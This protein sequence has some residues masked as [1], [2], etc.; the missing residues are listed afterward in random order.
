SRDQD[1]KYQYS[2]KNNEKMPEKTF[3]LLL[4]AIKY[5]KPDKGLRFTT[6][7]ALPKGSGLAGSS[8]LIIAIC[9]ALREYT[10]KKIMDEELI[11][12][13][14]SLEEKI[15]K[16]T[17]GWQDYYPAMYG[18][19]NILE[20]NNEGRHRN[21]NSILGSFHKEL[22]NKLIL[23]YTGEPHFSGTN[24]QEI[25]EKRKARDKNVIA[26]LEAVKQ[27]A[28]KMKEAVIS[29]DLEEFA[30]LLNEDWEN[31][32]LLSPKVTTNQIEKLIGASFEKGAKA[33]RVC[34]AGGGGCM[35]VLSNGNRFEI[36]N[37]LKENGA[38]ILDY[39][40]DYKGLDVRR[41]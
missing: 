20:F 28:I 25:L 6:D 7:V 38:E 11:E 36:E 26:A 35:V 22:E 10:K 8:A 34:G 23:C 16:T 13:A 17:A 41:D 4:E 30:K 15:I 5:F 3:D 12:I 32:K 29:E 37:T 1:I 19:L 40:F 18:G 14:R 9:G 27:T 2:S 33:A 21:S 39:E 24:N 31:R